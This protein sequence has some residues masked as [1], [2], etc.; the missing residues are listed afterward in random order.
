MTCVCLPGRILTRCSSRRVKLAHNGIGLAAN[1]GKD[2]YCEKPCTKNIAQSLLLAETFRRTGRV[3][4]AGTQR[5]SLPNFAFA[6]H[7]AREGKLGAL[8]T[9]HAHPCGLGTQMSG[10]PAKEVE[11]D[12]AFVDWDMAWAGGMAAVRW[13]AGRVQF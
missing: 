1:A 13:S 5:R 11:P 3:F 7:L 9:V 4:Q 2:V 10:W 12:P 6:C 8:K